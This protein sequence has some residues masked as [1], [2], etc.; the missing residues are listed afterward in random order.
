[1]KISDYINNEI[2]KDPGLEGRLDKVSRETDMVIN[3]YRK[4]E[5]ILTDFKNKK[6]GF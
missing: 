3:R 2:K 6:I 4:L 1:M 5:K